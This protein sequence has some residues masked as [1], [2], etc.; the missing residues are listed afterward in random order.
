[1]PQIGFFAAS[2][3]FFDTRSPQIPTLSRRGSSCSSH[4]GEFGQPTPCTFDRWSVP[5]KS[6]VTKANL[7]SQ[8]R[9][10]LIDGVSLINPPYKSL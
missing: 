9:A 1:M 7:A 3:L 2:I 6:R 5:Y 4:Q 10:R 8:P